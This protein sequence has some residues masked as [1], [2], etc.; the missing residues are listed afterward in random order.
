MKIQKIFSS[1]VAL[2]LIATMVAGNANIVSAHESIDTNTITLLRGTICPDCNS[3]QM[4]MRYTSW[5]YVGNF[6]QKCIHYP[7]G[8]D[9]M[10]T[11]SRNVYWKCPKC[12]LIQTGSKQTKHELSECHGFQ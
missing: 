10:T 12:G 6:Y 8:D 4:V 2:A 9:K 1:L 3:E 7:K 5:Q 11:F